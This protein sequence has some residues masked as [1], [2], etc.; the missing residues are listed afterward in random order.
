[1]L[2]RAQYGA[3][4][5][6]YLHLRSLIEW[7]YAKNHRLSAD[8]ESLC[9]EI[10]HEGTELSVTY[11]SAVLN[12]YATKQPQ[13]KADLLADLPR[14]ISSQ[15]ANEQLSALNTCRCQDTWNYNG[16]F[17]TIGAG[18]DIGADETL[19]IYPLYLPHLRR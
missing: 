15:N 6:D 1:M 3:R 9:F 2:N 18:P 10:L 17:R 13:V 19:F 4:Y 7:P 14:L 8:D 11:A 16:D 12:Y 5:N